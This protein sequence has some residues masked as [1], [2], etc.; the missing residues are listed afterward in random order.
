MTYRILSLDG[1]GIRGL[2][3]IILLQR[4]NQET[5]LAGWLDQVDLVAGTSTGGLLALAIAK[6]VDLQVLRD[7][8]ETKGKDVF[9]DSW[10]DDLRDLATI[11]GAEYNNKKLTRELKAIFGSTTLGELRHNLIVTTFDLDNEATDP[12]KRSWKPKIFHNLPGNDNDNNFLAYKVGLYTSAAPTYF[13]A[14][15]GYIDGG[16]FANNPSMCALAQT[17]DKR[18]QNKAPLQDVILLSLGTGTSLMYIK[19]KNLDWGYAQ[20]VKPLISLMLDGVGGIADYQCT[21]ILE[22][23]YHR[24]APTFPPN[25]SISLD[26]VKRIPE[27]VT[28]A[29][30]VPINN[31]ADWLR[32]FWQ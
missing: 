22:E 14:V 12:Q 29:N 32:N 21:Q 26:D 16:V 9:D 2:I 17:Q 28:F 23:R 5:S 10:L 25:V 8:Y 20:W 18:N 27:M 19:G 3:T 24:L 4:L 1:G 30:Q 7:L 15:D 6:G 31:T 13:P 11:I